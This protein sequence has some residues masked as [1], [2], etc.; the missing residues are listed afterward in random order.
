ME[1]DGSIIVDEYSRTS[2]SNI[3]AI[4]DVTNRLNLTPV[5][6]MEGMAFAATAF[7][8]TPTKPIHE[9]VNTCPMVLISKCGR[10]QSISADSDC[11]SFIKTATEGKPHDE[12]WWMQRLTMHHKHFCCGTSP[13]WGCAAMVYHRD[14][15]VH[16]LASACTNVH[17]AR[18]AKNKNCL[19]RSH[20]AAQM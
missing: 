6:I 18:V 13:L 17:H 10:S 7:G 3:Y 19:L 9:R 11:W 12:S 8:G 20:E 5:A 1:K 16:L 4:G 14:Y 15:E 2:A